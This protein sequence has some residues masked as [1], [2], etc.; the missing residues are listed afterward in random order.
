MEYTRVIL[1]QWYAQNGRQL[2][3]RETAN[4]YHIWVSEIILQ[5]TRVAQ[6]LDYFIRFIQRFPDVASLAEADED[7]VMRHWQGL[8]YYSRARNLQAAARQIMQAG[9]KFPDTYKEVRALKG[10]GDYTAAAICSFAYGLPHA[11]VDGNVYRVLSR[12]MAITT[13]ID[14]TKG[15]REFAQLADMLLDRDQPAL[16]N[17]AIMDFGATQCVPHHPDC[18]SCPLSHH[19]EAHQQGIVSQLPVKQHRTLTSDRYFNYIYVRAGGSTFIHKRSGND[20]WRNLYEFPLIETDTRLTEEQFYAHPLLQSF[21]APD[22]KPVVRL[23]QRGVRQVLSHRIIHAD[24]YEITLPADTHSFNGFLQIPIS[25][26]NDYP[27]HRM[28]ERFL[29]QLTNHE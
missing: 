5:Q 1:R 28:I 8:G 19:C 3:W 29:L 11:V 14:S 13:P 23:L 20:I 12:L 7:E 18:G 21:L 10:V 6:G 15:K 27:V 26:I 24:F 9:G 2:P 22:E 16:H 4:P 17:Q 25:S